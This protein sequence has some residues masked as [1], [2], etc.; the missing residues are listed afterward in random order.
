M[1]MEPRSF[2]R[3]EHSLYEQIHS[4]FS[5]IP[6]QYILTEQ[7]VKTTLN[8]SG[9]SDS[10]GGVT[11]FCTATLCKFYGKYPDFANEPDDFTFKSRDKAIQAI[12]RNVDAYPPQ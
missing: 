3:V 6:T 8:T 4:A 9:L 7:S 10:A 11:V 2:S 12:L 1:R 5:R